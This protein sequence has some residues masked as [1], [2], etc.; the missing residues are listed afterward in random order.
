MADNPFSQYSLDDQ[1][2]IADQLRTAMGSGKLNPAQLQG[3]QNAL[4]YLPQSKQQSDAQIA[5]LAGPKY[6]PSAP[7][8][9]FADYAT[10]NSPTAIAGR[11]GASVVHEPPNPR[12]GIVQYGQPGFLK[13]NPEEQQGLFAGAGMHARQVASE[14]QQMAEMNE[15]AT[16]FGQQ[17][18]GQFLQ[19]ALMMP[20]RKGQ[21]NPAQSVVK[22]T[23]EFAGGM[24]TDPT[25]YATMMLPTSS[26]ASGAFAAQGAYGTY[27][28][29]KQ[30]ADVWGRDD[31]PRERKIEL[32]TNIILNGLMAG[33]AGKHSIGEAISRFIDIPEADRAEIQQKIESQWYMTPNG[34]MYRRTPET[35][36]TN[37]QFIDTTDKQG[38]KLSQQYPAGSFYGR[39]VNRTPGKEPGPVVESAKNRIPVAPEPYPVTGTT[40]INKIAG[41][42]LIV[43]NRVPDQ[44]GTTSVPPTRTYTD[45]AGVTHYPNDLGGVSRTSGNEPPQESGAVPTEP[46]PKTPPPDYFNSAIPRKPGETPGEYRERVMNTPP[47]PDDPDLF[48]DEK[49]ALKDKEQS[50]PVESTPEGAVASA[51]YDN[52][53]DRL[54]TEHGLSQNAAKKLIGSALVGGK[55]YKP[56]P[57]AVETLNNLLG[58]ADTKALL[59]AHGAKPPESSAQKTPAG[60]SGITDLSLEALS[61]EQHGKPFAELS[62]EQQKA[63]HDYRHDWK[64][65]NLAGGVMLAGATDEVSARKILGDLVRNKMA[66]A[67]ALTSR[68]VKFRDETG[69]HFAAAF[70]AAPKP[71]ESGIEPATTREGNDELIAKVQSAERTFNEISRGKHGAILDQ[72]WEATTR[73]APEGTSKEANM[74]LYHKG[75][76]EL[77]RAIT[78]GRGFADFEKAFDIV[79]RKSEGGF[80]N[81][82]GRKRLSNDAVRMLSRLHVDTVLTRWENLPDGAM[83]GRR[84]VQKLSDP[85]LRNSVYGA[86]DP[87]L[88]ARYENLLRRVGAARATNPV[89][90]LAVGLDG[91]MITGKDVAQQSLREA[92]AVMAHTG[93]QRMAQLRGYRDAWNKRSIDDTIRFIDAIEGGRIEDLEGLDR[94]SAQ[95]LREHI[96]TRQ[97]QL[98]DAGLL[99][100]FN[101]NYFGRL[102]RYG[103]KDA[104]HAILTGRK[105]IAATPS[106][107]R[108]RTFATFSE[109]IAN[110]ME[111]VT[112]NPV[113]MFLLKS[114]EM[115]K[116]LAARN[117]FDELVRMKLV[118]QFDP[119]NIPWNWQ[120]L[121]HR[122]FN[123]GGAKLYAPAKV[124]NLFQRFLSPGLRGNV[125]YD[126]LANYNNVVN[127]FNLGFSAFH[128]T[129]T[130]INAAVSQAALGLQQMTRFGIIKDEGVGAYAKSVGKGIGN[131]VL[132]PSRPITALFTGAKIYQHYMTPDRFAE[133]DRYTQ[134]LDMAGGRVRMS[135]EYKNA[136]GQGFHNAWVEMKA[137]QGLQNIPKAG[138]L[139]YRSLGAGLEKMSAPLMDWFV[140]RMKLGV[141]AM[142]A[143]DAYNRL[144]EGAD[145]NAMRDEF[146][147][148]WDSIDNRFGQVVYDNLIWNRMGKDL[149]HLMI[150]SV[151]WN[152]GT[153]RELGGGVFNLNEYKGLATGKGLGYRQSYTLGLL[154]YTAMMGYLMNAWYQKTWTPQMSGLVDWLYPATG[155]QNP[156]GT[157]ERIYLKTYV[158]DA[159]GWMHAPG[160]QFVNKMAPEWHQIG[161]L[162]R[163]ADYYGTE[164]HPVHA[165][166]KDAALDPE[167]YTG[168]A[169]Y[170]A[171]GTEPFSVRNFVQRVESGE[172]AVSAL[173]SGA[174]ILPA[175]RWVNM[176]K[177]ESLAFEYYKANLSQ[178]PGDPMRH[179]S[180]VRYHQLANGFEQGRYTAQ[181]VT[182][183]F[184]AGE[185]TSNQFDGILDEKDGKLSPLERY[186]KQ[187]TPAQ[188]LRIW[189]A[190]SPDEKR[191]LSSRF[192]DTWQKVDDEYPANNP[193]TYKLLQEFKS[194]WKTYK[195]PEQSNLQ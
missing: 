188:L 28:S 127:Q 17:A 142:M 71:A 53:V 44:P 165:N 1:N 155:H 171:Q 96:D 182:K 132:S 130:A 106:A 8:Q 66:G 68:I 112:W 144:G 172:S 156:D 179:E 117:A 78:K 52:A 34:K 43:P 139:L 116:Y 49:D 57:P 15:A 118:Q 83:K 147:R 62:P 31:V 163:N 11:Q 173:S 140:P 146:S 131:V 21:A 55:S 7:T 23:G 16:S 20:Q 24:A 100:H 46:T 180:I 193:K 3:V 153:V 51:F 176:S 105:N 94:T 76:Q 91:H 174:A 61:Q 35:A 170:L 143:E 13:A 189:Q 152:Y 69:T 109:G 32:G 77:I 45:A 25:T 104:A 195:Q 151:G 72:L 126:T 110:G 59:E 39:Q 123:T 115:D 148:I 181:D 74:A 137:A 5:Q 113:D 9:S 159:F 102:W 192:L 133:M 166:V 121:D 56:H 60:A 6:R 122:M 162:Y 26:L 128:A 75:V 107:L 48:K 36:T 58:H 81:P 41:R 64:N 99:D 154:G 161:E 50:Q 12:T 135:A 103:I 30:L 54:V 141:F 98:I 87:Q 27:A 186:V 125:L 63:I 158:H 101:E 86:G 19:H 164:I 187:T 80:V 33:M 37:N 92:Q 4:K 38:G 124:V 175:P 191:V 157:K 169:K 111:P 120:P 183:A 190:A 178:G 184:K 22:A 136:A 88:E 185:I 84:I 47:E 14:T 85:L 114:A 42:Y 138:K 89:D 145:R 65:K 18:G 70:E 82:L 93:E 134:A 108:G 149:S 160:E 73:Y 95:I 2:Y 194:E 168:I 90:A 67:T 97:Q 10:M 177:A 40:N 150:R 167:T 29:G 79:T 119:K 129:G